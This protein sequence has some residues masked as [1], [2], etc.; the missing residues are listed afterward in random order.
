MAISDEKPDP[1]SVIGKAA[2]SNVGVMGI[3]A[4]AAGALTHEIDRSV[5]QNSAEARDFDRAVR[6]RAYAGDLGVSPAALAHR[7]ALSMSG[8]DTVVLGVKNRQE[9]NDCLQAE[10]LPRLTA[11]EMSQI[12][13]QIV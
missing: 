5:K 8:V 12:E 6:F 1:R 9:L 4:V 13:K 3:R 10:A 7:Y 11:D 2:E